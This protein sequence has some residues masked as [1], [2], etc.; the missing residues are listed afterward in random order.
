M[1]KQGRA[2]IVGVVSAGEGKYVYKIAGPWKD[3][4][5]VENDTAVFDLLNERG[6]GHITTLLK[7]CEGKNFVEEDDLFI[8]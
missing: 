3:R 8:Y 1:P 7:T 6:F 4:T 5:G 2:G